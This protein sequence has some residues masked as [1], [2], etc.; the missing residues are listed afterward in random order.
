[1]K[2]KVLT[3]TEINAALESIDVCKKTALVIAFTVVEKIRQRNNNNADMR[4]ADWI[5]ELQE[6]EDKMIFYNQ[7]GDTLCAV[8]EN[9]S[10]TNLLPVVKA[11]D[12]FKEVGESLAE[13]TQQDLHKKAE[14]L[15][16]AK[17]IKRIG[18]KHGNIEDLP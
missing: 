18:T 1:M 2:E 11:D 12:I 17:G 7:L 5:S 9:C 13:T 4:K 16:E 14:K 3:T 8:I 15:L 6:L 10:N